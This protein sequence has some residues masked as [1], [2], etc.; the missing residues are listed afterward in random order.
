MVFEFI[1]KKDWAQRWRDLLF[2][3]ELSKKDYDQYYQDIS[4]PSGLNIKGYSESEKTWKRLSKLIDFKY[5]KILDVGCFH[6][7]FSFKIEQ[8]GAKEIDGLEKK[9]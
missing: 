2:I 4:F 9:Q 3:S 1:D 7:F 6:G 8:A 5:Q